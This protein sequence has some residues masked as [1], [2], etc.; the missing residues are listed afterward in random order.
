MAWKLSSWLI[1]LRTFQLI[2][3]LACGSLNGVLIAIIITRHLGLS[4]AMTMLELLI[5]TLLAC[6][7]AALITQ[8]TGAR[9]KSK[10]WLVFFLVIDAV[11]CG[12]AISI[13]SILA[14]TGLPTNCGGLTRSDFSGDDAPNKPA[15]GYTTIRFSDQENGHKGELDRFCAFEQSYY[16]IA[17]GLIF[18]YMASIA[19]A[20][21]L[22]Y[23]QKYASNDNERLDLLERA[24][25]SEDKIL[26]TPSPLSQTPRLPV[27][28]P[29]PSEGIITR[30]TS[31]RSNITTA[32]QGPDFFRPNMPPRRPVGQALLPPRKPM[33]G[34]HMNNGLGLVHSGFV[35][36]PLDEE[37]DEAGIVAD[38]M[39]H[40]SRHN[41]QQRELQPLQ[42]LHHSHYQQ[43]QGE[44]Q[45]GS[46]QQ[47]QHQHQRM[48]MVPILEDQAADSALVSDGMRPSEPMLPPYQPGSSHM[49]GHGPN[50]NDLR[51]SEYVKGGTRAQDMKDNGEY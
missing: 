1:L 28:M 24:L 22:I 48:P 33:L 43:Y 49:P 13:I 9:H 27:N 2:G 36:V 39:Q 29:P 8:S 46:S 21:L 17:V 44:Q 47:Q 19:I 26:E 4:K 37:G 15:Y 10:P 51:L 25:A 7:V 18:T 11:F 12:V 16:F 14:G 32:T 45:P 40:H 5:A 23:E 35:P 20:A 3:A 42:P 38:G 31:V 41:M 34:P 50:D 30:N 6:T